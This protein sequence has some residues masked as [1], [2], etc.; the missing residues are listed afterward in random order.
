M[1]KQTRARK[2]L[3]GLVAPAGATGLPADEFGGASSCVCVVVA[4]AAVPRP[5]HD[6]Q[7]GTVMPAL[8]AG[9]GSTRGAR[10]GG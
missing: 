5:V 8:G 3:L 2:A 1:R 10:H 4:T 7:A 9:A 6:R